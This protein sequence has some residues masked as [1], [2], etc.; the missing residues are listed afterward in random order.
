[1]PSAR[2]GFSF[3]PHI[4]LFWSELAVAAVSRILSFQHI[5]HRLALVHHAAHFR[6]LETASANEVDGQPQVLGALAAIP[7]PIRSGTA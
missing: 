6:I 5:R 3:V 4:S 1:M 2:H 7:L